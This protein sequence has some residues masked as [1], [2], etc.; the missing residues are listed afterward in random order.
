MIPL[1]LDLILDFQQTR[2]IGPFC[3][4]TYFLDRSPRWILS[5]RSLQRF[6]RFILWPGF[7]V[8]H[9]HYN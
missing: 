1:Y 7:V 8:F 9:F 5:L 6:C 3:I 4:L 2:F